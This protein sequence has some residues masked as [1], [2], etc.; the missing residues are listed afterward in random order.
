MNSLVFKVGYAAKIFPMF[1]TLIRSFSSVK[2]LVLRK[3]R[4][5]VKTFSTFATLIWLFARM[6][7]MVF[8]K[9][10]VFSKGF[11]TFTIFV[12]LFSSMNSLVNKRLD[13]YLK[14]FPQTLQSF[15]FS[16]V[17]SLWCSMSQVSGVGPL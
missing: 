9:V 12:R 10:V 3:T 5:L 2:P 11:P 1:T 15:G 4:P 14:P 6:S 16:P 7:S 13:F 17:C 8:H